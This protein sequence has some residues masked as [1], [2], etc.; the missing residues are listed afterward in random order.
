MK[1]ILDSSYKAHDQSAGCYLEMAG[2][3][4]H[5]SIKQTREFTERFPLTFA[6]FLYISQM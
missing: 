2:N 5:H 4:T 6:L 3:Q 1:G